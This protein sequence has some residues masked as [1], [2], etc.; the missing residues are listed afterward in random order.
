MTKTSKPIVFFGTEDFSASS[1][2]ALIDAGYNIQL[3]VTKPDSAKGRGRQLSSPAVKEIANKH[4]IKVVQ[5]H[6]LQE[7]MEDIEVLDK[8]VGILVSFG[9]FVPQNIID[10]FT[11]GIINVHPS[12]LPIYRGASPIESAIF[13][14][15]KET[16]VSIMKL[17]KDMDAGP[18]YDQIK[19]QLSGTESRLDLYEKLAKAGADHLVEILTDIVEGNLQPTPQDNTKASYSHL[20]T[21]KQSYLV[22]STMTADEMERHVRAFFGFPRSRCMFMGYEIIVLK[23]HVSREKDNSLP[24]LIDSEGNYLSI[25]SLVGPSGKTMSG[26]AFLRGYGKN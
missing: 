26:E 6:D 18:V 24:Q 16:G 15:D 20:L 7:I 5:P 22:P 13:N 11:P 19:I 23:A 12:L 10:L 8:P 14:G 2:L 25:D 4:D 3:V 21:K 1:L 17:S 9:K